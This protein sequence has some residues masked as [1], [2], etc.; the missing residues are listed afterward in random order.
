MKDRREKIEKRIEM[1]M[2][3]AEKIEEKRKNDFLDKQEHFERAR[4]A[5]LMQQDQ[6]RYTY[7][8][9]FVLYKILICSFIGEFY[10][11]FYYC[12]LIKIFVQFVILIFY[13]NFVLSSFSTFFPLEC[14]ILK[15]WHYKNKEDK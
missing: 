4:M 7:F 11:L 3:M 8:S 1:N 6:D 5:H 10:W 2:S 12:F 14:C 9:N 13:V 15:K